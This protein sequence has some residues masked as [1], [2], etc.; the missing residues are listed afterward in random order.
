MTAGVVSSRTRVGKG[1]IGPLDRERDNHRAQVCVNLCIL[2]RLWVVEPAAS[3][4]ILST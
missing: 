2:A 3:G 4:T 1:P